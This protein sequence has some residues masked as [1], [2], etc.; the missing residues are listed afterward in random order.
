[1]RRVWR[2]ALFISIV[3]GAHAPTSA[4]TPAGLQGQPIELDVDPHARRV[5]HIK[6]ADSP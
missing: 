6:P 1:M 2:A 5:D 3:W 4:Q